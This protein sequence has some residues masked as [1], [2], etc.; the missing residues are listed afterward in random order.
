MK[1]NWNWSRSNLF[2]GLPAY[3]TGLRASYSLDDAW[4][5]SLGVYNGWNS[6]VDNNTEKS[7]A[8]VVN[9]QTRSLLAQFLYYGG[10]EWPT[11]APPGTAWRSDFDA[12][13]RWLTFDW[14]SLLAHLNTGLD[15]NHFGTSA[16]YAAALTARFRAAPWLYFAAR[17]DFFL[18]AP[19]DRLTGDCAAYFGADRG[20]SAR[21][22]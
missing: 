4:S 22:R 13:A 7:V 15:P 20:G 3:D 1:G 9:Y 21:G 5:I 2:A 8:L 19:R 16:W 10:T 17:G 6:V 14:L 11:G 12:Y 18:R